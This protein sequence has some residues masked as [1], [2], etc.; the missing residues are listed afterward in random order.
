MA[1]AGALGAQKSAMMAS[2]VVV[3]L[4][5]AVATVRSTLAAAAVLGVVMKVRAVLAAAAAKGEATLLTA[6]ALATLLVTLG[7]AAMMDAVLAAH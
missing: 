6:V 7:A 3:P 1:A 2:L 5:P 4:A